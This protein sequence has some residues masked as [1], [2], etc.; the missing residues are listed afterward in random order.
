V[1]DNIDLSERGLVEL[2]KAMFATRTA[3]QR[4]PILAACAERIEIAVA[5][6]DQR[7]K[8]ARQ[9][10][11]AGFVSSEVARLRAWAI[12]NDH[13]DLDDVLAAVSAEMKGGTRKHGHRS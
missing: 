2:R 8:I 6:G 13:W 4:E 10:Q 12:R 1:A 5:S 9:L 11:A 7:G 3:K